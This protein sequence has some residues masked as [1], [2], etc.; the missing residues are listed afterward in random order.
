MVDTMAPLLA[1]AATA[2]LAA[3]LFPISSEVALIAALAAGAGAPIPLIAAA[4][5][6]NVAGACLNWWLGRH[7]R[8]FEDRRWFPFSA[9]SIDRA[10]QRYQKWGLWSLFFSWLPLIGDPLTFAAGLLRVPLLYFLP[11]VAVGRVARYAV[12]ALAV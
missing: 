12:I 1:L 2:F 11:I 6:G 8:R 3:T 4:T 9:G 10:S 7:M 5:V